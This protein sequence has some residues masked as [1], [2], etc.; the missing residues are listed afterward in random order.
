MKQWEEG[1]NRVGSSEDK[2]LRECYELFV[3]YDY[4]SEVNMKE[5]FVD[6]LII[7]Q[8]RDEGFKRWVVTNHN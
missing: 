6:T 5:D 3:R 7:E 4:L 2:T 1:M 8:I